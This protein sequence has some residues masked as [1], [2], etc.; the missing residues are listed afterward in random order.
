VGGG[1]GGE[2]RALSKHSQ[3]AWAQETPNRSRK[4]RVWLLCQKSSKGDTASSQ[5]EQNSSK[6]FHTK[7][8]LGLKE[9][10]DKGGGRF[11]LLLHNLSGRLENMVQPSN[12]GRNRKSSPC[13]RC[14]DLVPGLG[15]FSKNL[16]LQ[17][18]QISLRDPRTSICAVGSSDW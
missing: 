11:C 2:G 7:H 13:N 1:A 14:E 16:P 6:V 5:E 15:N 9:L 3:E 12:D 4:C 18:V 10:N 17:L 8:M